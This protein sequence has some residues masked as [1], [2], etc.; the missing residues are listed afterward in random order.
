MTDVAFFAEPA[1]D[2]RDWRR[3]S[4]LTLLLAVVRLGPRSVQ[5]IPALA[6][7][8]IAGSWQYV[9]PALCLFLAVSLGFAWAAWL[10]FRWCI[11]DDAIVI[12]SGIFDRQHRTIPFDRIQDVSIEQ[13]L[14]ARALSI[15]RVSFETGA[16]GDADTGDGGLDS[17]GLDD[18][19]ALRTTIRDWRS[20]S[21]AAVT[22]GD[23]IIAA[24]QPVADD[25]A[26]FRLTP[27]RL[28]LA[29]L[30]N[31]SLAALAVVGFAAQW[32]DDLLPFDMFDPRVWIGFARD[33]GVEGWIMT[34]QW[35]AGVGAITALLLVGFVTGVVR[36]VL[37]NWN[38]LLT[39]GPRAFRRVRGLTT[40]TDVAIP[41]ARIQAAV[42]AT[43]AIRRRWGWHELRVQSLAAD[44]NEADHQLIPFG[45]MDD[46][47]P[48]LAITG[49][50]R[51]DDAIAAHQPPVAY[52]TIGGGLW[53]LGIAVGGGVVFSLIGWWGAL[54]LALAAI[55][56]VLALLDARR[57]RW[58]DDGR[59]L[60]IWRGWW[61]PR[62]TILPFA[63][64]Q[65]ADLAQGPLLRRFGCVAVELGVPGGG[66]FASHSIDAVPVAVAAA[67]R[68]RILATRVARA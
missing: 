35:V 44:G 36:T 5:M 22:S 25:R 29:G 13:G 54:G 57:H 60:Y 65:S 40:R 20:G 31:F 66:G 34:H 1:D 52:Q 49:H 12:E 11:G 41:I 8:G 21:V 33:A 32:F 59:I 10:R 9:V 58:A 16:S 4:P 23:T 67:L 24:A 19:A 30:F 45:Q 48:L 42:V 37:T 14:V 62:L 3:L 18:A 2:T 28:V 68:L 15:A 43:G 53:A 51:P 6:A 46:I 7:I 17:I 56:F 39:L 27:Q 47:D 63:N 38:F 55:V 64:V 26:L 61:S 50:A